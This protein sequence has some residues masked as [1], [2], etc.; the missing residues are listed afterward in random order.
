VAP[1]DCVE[2]MDGER[3][4]RNFLIEEEAAIRDAM[5]ER[6]VDLGKLS[7]EKAEQLLSP[8]SMGSQNRTA[9]WQD[10][11]TKLLGGMLHTLSRGFGTVCPHTLE[12]TRWSATYRW[13]V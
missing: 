13:Q 10:E 1:F 4:K 9:I 7:V 6:Q 11:S 8:R 12:V 5:K 2:K 3:I